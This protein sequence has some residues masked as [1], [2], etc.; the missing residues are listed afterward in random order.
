MHLPDL[1]STPHS[2]EEADHILYTD[3]AR[4]HQGRSYTVE[5][6][7]QA[8]QFH[9]RFGYRAFYAPNCIIFYKP[10]G[11]GGVE[12]HS[13]N[14]GSARDLSSGINAMLTQLAAVPG[15]TKAFTYYDNPRL[16]ELLKHSKYVATSRRLDEGEDRTFEASFNL[17]ILNG[18]C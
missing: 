15:V 2:A 4:N 10:L 8:L 14:G 7:R 18:L 12:F 3:F 17:E 9:G 1:T 16:N 13:V 6:S 11:A 5:A